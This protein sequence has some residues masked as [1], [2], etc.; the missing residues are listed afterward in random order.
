MK[1]TFLSRTY[2]RKLTYSAMFLTIALLLPQVFHQ[3]KD[4]GRIFLPMHL[5]VILC[6]FIVGWP[7]GL[8]IGLIAPLLSSALFGMPVIFP[9]GVA[10]ALELAA[11]GLISGLLWN[12]FPKKIPFLYLA[13]IS[14]MVSGR[15]ISGSV[16]YLIAGL[17][18]TEF[19]LS[20]FWTGTVILALPGII[21]QF[22]L[23]PLLV[24]AL[25]RASLVLNKK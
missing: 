9:T 13:L 15:I 11:Y 10:M 23:I 19:S 3:F 16:Q 20:A 4:F 21:I 7:W 22:I 12:L 6:G 5:P 2:I 1:K 17:K 14:S 25:R 18:N 24:I 8:A